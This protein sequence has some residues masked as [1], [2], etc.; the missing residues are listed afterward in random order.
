MEYVLALTLSYLGVLFIH[1]IH[2]RLNSRPPVPDGLIHTI[3]N[4][5]IFDRQQVTRPN[6]PQLRVP[7]QKPR[8]Q[9]VLHETGLHHQ[10]LPERG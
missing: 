1:F 9:L 2:G 7:V 5:W 8:C 6:A 10:F 4:I 3:R